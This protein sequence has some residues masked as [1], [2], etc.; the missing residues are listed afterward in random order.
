MPCAARIVPALAVTWLAAM[1]LWTGPAHAD[2]A[3]R[4]ATL[5]EALRIEETVRIMHDE[6]LVYGASL[7]RDMMPEADTESWR[8]RVARIY[9]P[10]R[11]RALVVAGLEE[12]LAD[13]PL[14]P[15]VDFFTSGLGHKV[16]ALEL[17]TREAFLDRATEDAAREAY[18][19]L[20]DTRAPILGR[21]ETLIDDSDLVERNVTGILNSNLMLY[22]GLV[23][24]GAYEMSGEDILRDVRAQAD[25]VRADSA[26]WIGAYLLAAYRPLPPEEL[27]RYIAFWRSDPGRALNRAL[28]A[29][30]DRMY[31]EVSYLLGQSMAQYMRGRKL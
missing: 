24:G 28:F 16:V 19:A 10:E 9:D 5:V 3:A 23:D 12:G 11:M 13:V 27:D 17:S 22:R 1:L 8:R 6:G 20:A 29:T 2:R 25:S 15:L 18:A 7:A 31:E 14:A 4:M 26:E 30:Y 21:I